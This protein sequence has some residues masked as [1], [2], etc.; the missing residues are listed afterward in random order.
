MRC[1]TDMLSIAQIFSSHYYPIPNGIVEKFPHLDR[2]LKQMLAKVAE[3]PTEWD[4]YLP[5][6]LLFMYNEA[7]HKSTCLSSHEI[8]FGL[9]IHGLTIFGLT[10]TLSLLRDLWIRLDITQYQTY[11]TYLT[12][13]NTAYH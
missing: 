8:I 12:D 10:I 4:R 11:N 6:M 1:F 3:F 7:P 5:A 9:T 13:L 2:C